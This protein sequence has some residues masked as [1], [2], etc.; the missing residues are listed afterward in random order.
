M[1]KRYALWVLMPLIVISC[2]VQEENKQLKQENDQLKAELEQAQMSAQTLEEVG[3]LIDSIDAARDVLWL[4]LESG[5]SYESYQDK[6]RA[7]DSYMKDSEDRINKL[8]S[9]LAKSNTQNSV[10]YNSVRS[11][12]KQLATKQ[13]EIEE[14]NQR[15]EKYKSENEALIKTVDLQSRELADQEKE[16][17]AKRE[18]LQGLEEQIENLNL[19]AKESE[20]DAYFSMGEIKEET[21]KRTKLAPR[22]RKETYKEALDFYRKAFEGGRKDAYQKIEE[23]EKKV[24]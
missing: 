11:M 16:I 12:K 6:I 24:N 1:I 8:E 5:T 22:K 17:K 2:G 13:A 10:Y 20:A 4:D 23:L 3:T 19:V 18:E 9:E 14:L 21:A 7:I 15:V